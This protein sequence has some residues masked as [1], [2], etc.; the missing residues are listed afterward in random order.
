MKNSIV[1]TYDGKSL[2]WAGLDEGLLGLIK[3]AAS[4]LLRY[5]KSQIYDIIALIEFQ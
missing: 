2:A 5:C 3:I 1:C 4:K